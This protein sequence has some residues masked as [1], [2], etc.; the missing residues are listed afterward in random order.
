M[1]YQWLVWV[2]VHVRVLFQGLKSVCFHTCLSSFS[3]FHYSNC[4]QNLYMSFTVSSLSSLPPLPPSS[5][6]LPLSLP[7]SPPAE[8]YIYCPWMAPQSVQIESGCRIGIDY[9]HPVVD[10][11]TAGA[12]CCEKL[13]RVMTLLQQTRTLCCQQSICPSIPTTTVPSTTVSQPHP[14]GPYKCLDVLCAACMTRENNTHYGDHKR[15]IMMI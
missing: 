13:R 9:P 4:R 3:N 14:P 10:H 11:A 1:C 5:L 6:P 8:E 15:C 7:P 2:C 12:L